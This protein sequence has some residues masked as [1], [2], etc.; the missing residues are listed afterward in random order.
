VFP[1][2]CPAFRPAAAVATVG[3]MA[4]GRV[5]DRVWRGLWISVSQV[6]QVLLNGTDMLLIGT[7]LGPSAVVVYS[8]TG[9]LLL[10]L[11]NQP[12]LFMQ[13]A[14]PA[15]SELRA[16][17]SRDRLF[18]LSTAMSQ[19]MLLGTGAI[20]CVVL[21][22]NEGFVAWWVGPE[23]FGGTLLTGVLLLALILRHWND[24]LSYTLFSL[25]HERRL[26]LTSIADGLVTVGAMLVLIPRFGMPGAALA[27]VAGLV[28]VSLP[29]KLGA[30][31][32]EEGVPVLAAVA[33][34][35]PWAARLAALALAVAAAAAAWTPRG[36]VPVAVTGAVVSTVYLLGMRGVLASPLIGPRVAAALEPGV[37]RLP[38]AWRR[39]A[40][41][42]IPQLN[43]QTTS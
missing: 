10:L 42:A 27:S 37:R 28:L 4:R 24:A 25:G 41:L 26:A 20:A 12:Q 21:A 23:R 38:P 13:M 14:A 7:L 29:S 33:P 8:C 34:L 6:A 17:A 11:G 5:P 15:L 43:T 9:K 40:G 1:D 16:T 22:V 3:A 32:R 19:A 2:A 39:M 18:Q 31:A 35:G 30:L 36:V